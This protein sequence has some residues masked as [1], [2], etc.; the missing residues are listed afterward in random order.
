M[1]LLNS[2]KLCAFGRCISPLPFRLRYSAHVAFPGRSH[3]A[4][5]AQHRH[6][7]TQTGFSTECLHH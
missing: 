1:C 7:T 6:R 2:E 3:I 4:C 5:A